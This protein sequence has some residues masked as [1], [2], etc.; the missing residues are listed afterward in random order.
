MRKA[1]SV[2]VTLVAIGALAYIFLGQ[3]HAAPEAPVLRSAALASPTDTAAPIIPLSG[4]SSGASGSSAGPSSKANS[5]SASKKRS[6]VLNIRSKKIH[7][8]ECSSVNDMSD[9]NRVDIYSTYLEILKT[10]KYKNFKPC[11]RCH[12]EKYK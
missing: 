5:S 2:I 12:P 8:L 7:L 6:F 3:P 11:Q 1:Y 4:G 10:S 9:S